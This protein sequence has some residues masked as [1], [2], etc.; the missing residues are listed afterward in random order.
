MVTAGLPDFHPVQNN[1]SY[2]E[3]RGT[4]RGIHAEPWDKFVS[5]ATGRI[6]G[7]W[8]DLREGNDFGCVF[9]AEIGPEDAVFVPRGVAN[10]YQTLE[11][12]TAYVYLVNDH[13]KPDG[14][15]VFVNLA[16]ESLGIEWPIALEDVE[17]SAKDRA[18][19]PLRDVDPIPAAPTDPNTSRTLILGAGGQL[20]RALVKLLPEAIAWARA[21]FD[22]GDPD[23]FEDV[24][25]SRF[26]TIINA[27]A[28]TKVDEAETTEGR[29]SAWRVNAH[30]PAH[31]A[32]VAITYD[33]A[34]LHISSDYVFDGIEN[35]HATSEQFSPLSVYGASKA[36]GDLAVSTVP[37]H[38]IVR[39]SWVIGEGKNFISTMIDL[40]EKGIDPQVVN[41]QI[42]RITFASDLAEAIV[43]MLEADDLPP[44][45][46]VTS[47]GPVRSWADIAREAFESA[48]HDPDR[49]TEVSTTD[50]SRGKNLAPRPMFSVL[51]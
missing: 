8:V 32:R 44:V 9:T 18:H 34:L 26:D 48:G 1:V 23:A 41:D 19:P 43:A 42:G 49:V 20:G 45:A 13:W 46:H 40:A 22:I 28:Y 3:V 7:A 50:Y 12:N 17:I 10:S 6:F 33:I 39:T 21:D 4:T 11:E 35:V 2:N 14:D 38:C 5:V 16:D 47:G 15:Y 27:A 25:W 36:A 24:D 31:L 30:G 51:A 29:R 37:K